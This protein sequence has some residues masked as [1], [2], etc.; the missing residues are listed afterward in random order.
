MRLL[1]AFCLITFGPATGAAAQSRSDAREVLRSVMAIQV[2]L[3]RRAEEEP[4]P[5][6]RRKVAGPSPGGIPE[7]VEEWEHP[8][9][10][11][12]RPPLP[13]GTRIRTIDSDQ[14]R[15]SPFSSWR[16]PAAVHRGYFEY[17]EELTG[18]EGRQ[19]DEAE[20][21]LL[22]APLQ[23]H[24]VKRIDPAWLAAPLAFCAGDD[25]WPY[26][27]ISSPVFHGDFT[28]VYSSFQCALCGQG[29]ILA[30]KRA[31]PRWRLIAIAPKWVS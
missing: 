23:R 27:E 6:V 2:D 15:F 28:F 4:P 26:L 18:P 16:R 14:V 22:M 8:R 30:F 25:Q 7:V 5:C 11:P 12:P 13:P 31:G 19:I 3:H 10:K 24:R 9:P 20:R 21:A 1:V 17:H 29:V